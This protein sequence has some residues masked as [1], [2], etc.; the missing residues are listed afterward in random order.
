MLN[1]ADL[2][3]LQQLIKITQQLRD[4]ETGCEWDKKQT[5]DSI[6]SCTLEETYEVLDAIDR[7]DFA[8]LKGELGDL[9]FQIV[10]YA[11]LAQEQNHFNFDDICQA[12]SQ[13]LISRHPHVFAGLQSEQDNKNWEQ[14]KQVERAERQQFSILDDIPQSLPALMRAEKIQ[15]RCASVGFDWDTLKPVLDKVYEE[16][17]EVMFEVNQPHID[18]EKLTEEVGDLL[19]AT[20]NFS[21]HLGQK[22][23][24]VLQQANQKFERRFRQV[25]QLLQAKNIA[26]NDATLE[27]MEQAWQI[28]KQQEK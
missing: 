13:K 9:L 24:L 15:K 28:V 27:Q 10:F 17:D 4:P 25:E 6:K 1:Q 8:E 20:V 22:S 23:E 16:I 14:R 19:F 2:T 18:Q 12:I 7:K 5:F 3:P 21:R 26:F 11:D